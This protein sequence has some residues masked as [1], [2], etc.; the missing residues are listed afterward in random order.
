MKILH[1]IGDKKTPNYNTRQ[2]VID[3]KDTLT[4]DGVYKNV[5]ENRDIL[6]DKD[7]ILFITGDYIGGNNDFDIKAPLNGA[8]IYP[9]DFTDWQQICELV[10]MGCKL[11]WHTWSHRDLTKL[12]REEQIKEIT[13]PFPMDY[14]AYPYGVFNQD[15]I[16]LVKQAGF[17]KAYSVFQGDNSDYQILRSFI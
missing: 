13:P 6:K 3:C 12:S 9:E 14:F 4:F 2:Q 7:V 15:I 1:N 11:G 10:N 17:K 8:L 5:W 16:E